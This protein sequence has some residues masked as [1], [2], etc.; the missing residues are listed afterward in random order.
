MFS[1]LLKFVYK[2]QGVSPDQ[3]VKANKVVKQEIAKFFKEYGK[4]DPNKVECYYFKSNRWKFKFEEILGKFSVY[5][6]FEIQVG[7]N[8]RI[9]IELPYNSN[10]I[11]SGIKIIIGKNNDVIIPNYLIKEFYKNTE[12]AAEFIEEAFLD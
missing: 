1:N 11:N 9:R 5:A 7:N 8:F 12:K 4:I 10:D 6:K 2:Q 3:I